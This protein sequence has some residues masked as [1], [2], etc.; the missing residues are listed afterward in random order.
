MESM[1]E[2]V[3]LSQPKEKTIPEIPKISF[4]KTQIQNQQSRNL[5]QDLQNYTA[6]PSSTDKN[7]VNQ[8]QDNKILKTEESDSKSKASGNVYENFGFSDKQHVIK[9][10]VDTNSKKRS[11]G[12]ENLL[13]FEQKDLSSTQSGLISV[14]K[15]Q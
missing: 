2:I 4:K 6:Q 14:P 15:S 11:I 10:L 13:Q 3:A 12:R 8:S 9:K 1:Q 5:N 7:M